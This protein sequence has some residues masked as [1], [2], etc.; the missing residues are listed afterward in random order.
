MLRQAIA[1]KRKALGDRDPEVAEDQVVLADML[2]DRGDFVVAES[3]YRAALVIQR[4]TLRVQNRFTPRTLLG[5]GRS[6]LA[7]GDREAAEQFLREAVAMLRAVRQFDTPRIA[8]AESAL[9][10]ARAATGH[11]R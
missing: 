2:A 7:R 3:L 8:E 6:L 11:P 1:V 4:E 9:A 5:L 10:R